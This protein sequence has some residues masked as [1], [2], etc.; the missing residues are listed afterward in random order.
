M[1]TKFASRPYPVDFPCFNREGYAMELD[2]GLIRAESDILTNVQRRSYTNLPTMILVSTNIPVAQLYDFS[3]WLNNNVGVW[4]DLPLAHPFMTRNRKVE[5][6]PARI[7]DF[8]LPNS[9][10]VH[11]VVVCALTIQLSP[12]V[13]IDSRAPEVPWEWII[14]GNV[15]FPSPDWTIARR[16]TSPATDWIIAGSASNPG[17]LDSGLS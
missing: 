2:L 14:A 1:I 9:Y 4:V 12:T 13:F 8:T 11:G 17:G 3:I 6:V 10:Q 16:V 15:P 5:I 7:I